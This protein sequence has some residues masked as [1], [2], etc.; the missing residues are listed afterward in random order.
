MPTK[1]NSK[2][3]QNYYK[4]QTQ[5]GWVRKLHIVELKGG[6]CQVCGYSK[7][8]RALSF[9]HRDPK[10]KKIKLD[11]RTIGN[12]K[13]SRILDEVDKCD[14]LCIR[15][16]LELHDAETNKDY[17]LYEIKRK[18]R[19]D[20]LCL[21]CGI[22]FPQ[23]QSKLNV[24]KGCYCSKKCASVAQRRTVWP[25]KEELKELLWSIPTTH[26]GE[27]FGVSDKAV[28]KWAKKYGLDKPPRGYWS[29]KYWSEKNS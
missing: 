8:M 20:C 25:N 17:M 3:S 27:K 28:H 2:Y 21:N 6:K 26:I 4:R 5:R 24:G 23:L 15:C 1:Y 22:E 18:E 7:C 10:L 29:K 12:L 9:H 16:H 13:W 11:L 19:K 14:L